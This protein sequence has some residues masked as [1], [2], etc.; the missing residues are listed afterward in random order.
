MKRIFI[1]EGLM[2]LNMSKTFCHL[3]RL[4]TW[5]L[6]DIFRSSC[7]VTHFLRIALFK[8]Q[9]KTILQQVCVISESFMSNCTFL[10]QISGKHISFSMIRPSV[11]VIQFTKVGICSKRRNLNISSFLRFVP[12]LWIIDKHCNKIIEPATNKYVGHTRA[13]Y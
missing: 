1:C 11:L 5:H 3:W 6:M 2:F 13:I 7:W 12:V 8:D 9:A 10:Q 4:G